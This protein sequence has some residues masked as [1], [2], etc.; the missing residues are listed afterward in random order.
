MNAHV[1]S[2]TRPCKICNDITVDIVQPN[3]LPEV[4]IWKANCGLILV[5]PIRCKVSFTKAEIVYLSVFLKLSR[6]IPVELDIILFVARL[7]GPLQDTGSVDSTVIGGGYIFANTNAR[8]IKSFPDNLRLDCSLDI[9]LTLRIS[10]VSNE[11][12]TCRRGPVIVFGI[13]VHKPIV[14]SYGGTWVHCGDARKFIRLGGSKFATETLTSCL[15]HDSSRVSH[16]KDRAWLLHC[17]GR[18]KDISAGRC[19]GGI[20]CFSISAQ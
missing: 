8:C 4:A 13:W 5:S 1:I 19:R 20:I 7:G 17:L 16:D 9:N 6:D 2:L 14:L 12:F 15:C 3:V 10:F 11:G 18:S